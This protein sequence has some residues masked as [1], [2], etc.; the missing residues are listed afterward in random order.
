MVEVRELDVQLQHVRIL[1]GGVGDQPSDDT[2]DSAAAIDITPA[3]RSRRGSTTLRFTATTT[4]A[5][6]T[7]AATATMTVSRR[8]TR[9]VWMH[10][11]AARAEFAGE[12]QAQR[13]DLPKR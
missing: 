3:T 11:R 8:C 1:A 2:G 9:S 10:N 13:L 4:G 6:H 5:V 7:T 12:V